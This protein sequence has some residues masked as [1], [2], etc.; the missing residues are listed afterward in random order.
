[1]NILN[2]KK[3]GLGLFFYANYSF[4]NEKFRKRF[5][6][7][8]AIKSNILAIFLCYLLKG[9]EYTNK[10]RIS[11]LEDFRKKLGE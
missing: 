5:F 1:M 2:S 10:T 11:I 4:R 9:Q 3:T 6:V 8:T 7:K